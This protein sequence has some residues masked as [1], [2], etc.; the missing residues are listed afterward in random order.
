MNSS[1]F[2]SYIILLVFSQGAFGHSR[3]CSSSANE[4]RCVIRDHP[5]NY[6]DNQEKFWQVLNIAR[7][8]A[9]SCK[10]RKDAVEFLKLSNL[11]NQGADLQ[12][13]LSEGVETLCAKQPICFKQ[14]VKD[15]T[16]NDRRKV[17]MMVKNPT[18][19]DSNELL[20]CIPTKR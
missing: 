13:F 17:F 18:F 9:I 7:D 4:L 3:E 19:F 20:S 14:A 6:R 10:S 12:E 8:R 1:K 5:K 2:F 16:Y 11:P 15:L